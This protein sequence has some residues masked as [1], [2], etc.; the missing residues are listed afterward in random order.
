M[1]EHVF[2]MPT[3]DAN[4]DKHEYADQV[5]AAFAQTLARMQPGERLVYHIGKYAGDTP[6]GKAAWLAHEAGKVSLVQRRV[7]PRKFDYIA[8]VRG[9]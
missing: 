5:R 7:G 3:R 9:K 1:T 6:A 4:T 8:Q 2:D